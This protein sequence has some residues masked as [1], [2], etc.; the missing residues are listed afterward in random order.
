MTGAMRVQTTA[1]WHP[2]TGWTLRNT[3]ATTVRVLP[4]AFTHTVRKPFRSGRAAQGV[5]TQVTDPELSRVVHDLYCDMF[6]RGYRQVTRHV[7]HPATGL[8]LVLFTVFIYAFDDEFEVRRRQHAATEL[9]RI[10]ESPAVKEVWDALG[11]YLENLDRTDAV[12]RYVVDDFLAPRLGD[13]R[14]DVDA[15]AAGPDFTTTARL[16]A[17]DSGEALHTAY[18]LIRLFNGHPRSDAC[19]EQFRRLGLAGKFLDDIADYAD[20][21]R[22]QNPNLLDALAARAPSEF[23]AA[24]A[25]LDAAVP[26][27]WAWWRRHAPD[28]YRRYVAD[29]H[30]HYARVTAPA[31]RL[32]LD[33]Y[34]ALLHTKRFWNISTVRA[35]RRDG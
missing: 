32:P 28:T 14:R 21:V 8:A 1:R 5:T 2:E 17:F 30:E 11:R 7:V 35:S 29:T 6:L 31:L 27:T 20:D 16:V 26:V 24:R 34:L 13:Y 23:H 3:A 9:S 10:L 18:H 22:S 25:A 33:V 15:A 4:F 19:A 12:R